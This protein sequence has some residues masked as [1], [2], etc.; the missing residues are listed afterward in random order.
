MC[1]FLYFQGYHLYYA[2]FVSRN[3]I[4]VRHLMVVQPLYSLVILIVAHLLVSHIMDSHI[5]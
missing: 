3:N 1:T 4:R 5:N 2:S